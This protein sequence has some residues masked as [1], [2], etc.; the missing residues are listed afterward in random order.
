VEES[1][2]LQATHDFLL[3][4]PKKLEE[5]DH[6]LFPGPLPRTCIGAFLLSALATPYKN[7]DGIQL[8]IIVR[9]ILGLFVAFS[10]ARI[11]FAVARNLG[12]EVSR[13]FI[14]V[15]SVQFHLMF[16]SSRT[17]PNVFAFGIVNLALGNW[18]DLTGPVYNEYVP[19][20]PTSLTKQTERA[21]NRVNSH[22]WMVWLLVFASIVFRMEV[23][24]FSGCLLV[25][26]WIFQEG[27]SEQDAW[28]LLTDGFFASVFS[29]S[30]TVGIDRWFWKGWIWPEFNSFVY[31]AIEGKSANWGVSPRW[32]YFTN[33]LPRISM[34]ALPLALMGATM[35]R[36]M[37]L[38]LLPCF[39]YMAIYSMLGHKEWR[40]IVYV[41]PLVNIVAAYTLSKLA[42]HG[43]N[44]VLALLFYGAVFSLILNA[45]ISGFTLHISTH[46]YPGG[47]AL[48]ELHILERETTGVYVHMDSGSCQTGITRFG[49]IR[50]DWTYSKNES[51]RLPYDYLVAGYTHLITSDILLHKPL[52]HWDVIKSIEGVESVHFLPVGQ[53]WQA[54]KAAFSALDVRMLIPVEVVLHESVHILRRK[55]FHQKNRPMT[56]FK[57][58]R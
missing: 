41:L 45:I 15:C 53:Y 35:S 56:T 36:R 17:L 23:A 10:L 58:L 57:E 11:R 21:K 8:Q 33:L 12:L 46:N 39:T 55:D 40:F 31:N 51:H 20:V 16:W 48:R 26:L 18:I 22:S 38:Y 6:W 3:L 5:F 30:L 25:T 44:P 1:F 49:E 24:V 13:W 50:K 28:N 37:R 52:E 54:V 9:S 7:L 43:G 32:Y 42:K 27:M 34:A 4:G 2:N 19:R 14:L 47:N 29:L